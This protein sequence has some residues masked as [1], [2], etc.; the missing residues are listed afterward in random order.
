MLI[1]IGSGS[2]VYG[3]DSDLQQLENNNDPLQLL[4]KK[5]PIPND[6]F[7]LFAKKAE[8]KAEEES[9]ISR[10]VVKKMT[11][12]N[13]QCSICYKIE[14]KQLQYSKYYKDRNR[15]LDRVPL[16]LKYEVFRL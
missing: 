4:D 10:V 1:C 15:L 11:G 12:F 2:Y 6:L 8:E 7:Q 16:C 13:A 9:A 5:Q 14:Q 3:S